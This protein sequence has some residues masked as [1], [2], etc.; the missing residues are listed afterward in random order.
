MPGTST[1]VSRAE[2]KGR[3]LLAVISGTGQAAPATVWRWEYLTCT[4][5]ALHADRV[6]R[7]ERPGSSSGLHN[8]EKTPFT[9][10]T[11]RMAALVR[12]SLFPGFS[13]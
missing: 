6:Q 3:A 1:R 4:C 13:V 7:P 9:V 12:V 2:S 5:V 10:V 11:F 8:A